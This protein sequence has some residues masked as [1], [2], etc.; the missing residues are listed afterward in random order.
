MKPFPMGNG[1]IQVRPLRAGGGFPAVF[2]VEV[3]DIA[4]GRSVVLTT[5]GE[6]AGKF[7]NQFNR[8]IGRVDTEDGVPEPVSAGRRGW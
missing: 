3:Q 8:V 4:R 2:I 1:T 5:T 6:D 7:I